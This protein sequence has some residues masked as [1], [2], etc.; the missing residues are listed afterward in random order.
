MKNKH[1]ILAALTILALL[2]GN[3]LLLPRLLAFAQALP[4][5]EVVT[6]PT[7]DATA[8]V[9][10]PTPPEGFGVPY[11]LKFSRPLSEEEQEM[12]NSL[13]SDMH[14]LDKLRLFGETAAVT[15]TQRAQERL[16]EAN[17]N[18]IT[19]PDRYRQY[20]LGD[21][22]IGDGVPGTILIDL[23]TVTVCVGDEPLTREAAIP[24]MR[25]V[26]RNADGA[27]VDGSFNRMY[28]DFSWMEK[29]RTQQYTLS[30]GLCDNELPRYMRL[31]TDYMLSG[32]RPTTPLATSETPDGGLWFDESTATLHLPMRYELMDDEMLRYIELTDTLT[33]QA[34]LLKTPDMIPQQ[35]AVEIAKDWAEKLFGMDVSGLSA[36]ATLEDGSLFDG[37]GAL[38]RVR[39]GPEDMLVR[40]IGNDYSYEGCEFQINAADG[41]LDFAY[42]SRGSGQVVPSNKGIKQVKA[43]LKRK[44][45]ETVQA[46]FEGGRKPKKAVINVCGYATDDDNFNLDESKITSISY[47]V[48]MSGGVEYELEFTTADYALFSYRYWPDG[49]KDMG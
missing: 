30:R 47:V 37:P 18:G 29:E 26:L 1:G 25:Q 19:D 10:L 21:Y 12:W 27:N 22:P 49:C 2:A 9:L 24:L 36:F 11:E 16:L 35:K 39:F 14:S 48:S 7:V 3:A 46:L 40:E 43:D 41:A 28:R 23:G 17:L 34:L 32:L 13:D 5:G 15:Y 45:I 4:E 33:R 6:Q 44:A 8:R 38:W 42:L 31:K 20:M